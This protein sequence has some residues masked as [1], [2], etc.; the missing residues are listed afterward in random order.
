MPE[1]RARPVVVVTDDEPHIRAIVVAKLRAAGYDVHEAGDGQEALSLTR[2]VHPDLLITDLQMPYMSGLELCVA[3]RAD[4]A[5]SAIPALLL[6]ARG[7]L[8]SDEQISQTNI[9]GVRSKPFS[10]RDVLQDAQRLMQKA[11]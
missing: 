10:V 7:F 1:D 3:L 5:T 8:V 9:R 6:T 2:E 11:A 4:P